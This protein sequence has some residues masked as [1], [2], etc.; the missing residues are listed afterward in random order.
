MKA[1]DSKIPLQE[2]YADLAKKSLIRVQYSCSGNSSTVEESDFISYRKGMDEDLPEIATLLAGNNL[3]ISD[4]LPGKQ[5]FIVAEIDHKIIG[6]VGFEGYD[7]S[8][9]LRSLVVSQDYRNLNIA[10]ILIE[11]ILLLGKEQGI[12]EFYLLTTTAG[13]FFE[14]LGWKNINRFQVSEEIKSTAEFSSLCPSVAS[15]MSF[16]L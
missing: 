16:T 5:H 11:K 7:K 8:G 6:C 10:H 14:K 15:C 13:S 12:Q 2:K 1:E 4:I 3:P 9:L